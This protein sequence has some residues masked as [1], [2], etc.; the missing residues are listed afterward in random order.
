MHRYIGNNL[1]VTNLSLQ[2]N[3]V[4]VDVYMHIGLIKFAYQCAYSMQRQK[5]L[6]V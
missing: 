4:S 3:Y 6:D 2:F 5:N 1:I